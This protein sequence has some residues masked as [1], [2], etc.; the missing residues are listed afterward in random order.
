MD[1]TQKEAQRQRRERERGKK[2]T[3]YVNTHPWRQKVLEPQEWL[4]YETRCIEPRCSTADCKRALEQEYCRY[5]NTQ[6]MN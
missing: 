6:K 4:H 1:R 3:S 5:T 2:I